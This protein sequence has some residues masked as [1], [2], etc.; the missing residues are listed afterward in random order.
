VKGIEVY[1]VRIGWDYVRSGW[2]RAVLSTLA[3]MAGKVPTIS[4]T[5][6]AVM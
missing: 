5:G 1:Y 3:I 4:M 6:A 2:S